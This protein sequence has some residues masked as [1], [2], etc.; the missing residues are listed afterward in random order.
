[1][2]RRRTA[3]ALAKS[4][5]AADTTATATTTTTTATCSACCQVGNSRRSNHLCPFYIPR[6]RVEIRAKSAVP[7]VSR[8]VKIGFG[9]LLAFG[10]L[11]GP[12]ESAV[13]RL[14]KITFDASRLLNIHMSKVCA[15]GGE[16]PNLPN[17]IRLYLQAV[18]FNTRE[19]NLHQG[20]PTLNEGINHIRDASF[21]AEHQFTDSK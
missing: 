9:S 15:D 4:R 18:G 13:A 7:M 3:Q 12:I 8:T 6:Q 1:M 16:I 21:P 17:T 20:A 19:G 10:P 14:G 5:L 2:K 11:A